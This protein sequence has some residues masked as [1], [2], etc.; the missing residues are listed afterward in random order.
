MSMNSTDPIAD[1]LTR[2]RN[3]ASVSK[4]EVRL[5]HSKIKETI[6]N[7]LVKNGFIKNVIVEKGTPRNTIVI[8]I[9][10]VGEPVKFTEIV[11]MSTPGRRYYT[12]VKEIPRIKNGRG[13]VLISTSKGVMSG[14]EAAKARLGG[15]IICKIY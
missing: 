3:A 6:A 14:A 11:R 9:N 1:M 10:N 12:G 13:I 2:I 5:P 8:T 15:E 4:N 7:E